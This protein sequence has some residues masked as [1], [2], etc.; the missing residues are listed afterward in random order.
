LR[1]A[2]K[3]GENMDLIEL[4]KSP[5]VYKKAAHDEWDEIYES[6]TYLYDDV[7]NQFIERKNYGRD[8]S[9]DTS[10]NYERTESKTIRKKDLPA[11]A[12]KAWNQLNK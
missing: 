4:Y 11:E 10:A 2:R 3:K 7:K 12:L 5:T 9:R 8:N 1:Y 6:Y